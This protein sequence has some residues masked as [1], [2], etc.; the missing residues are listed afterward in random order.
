MICPGWRRGTATSRIQD[1]PRT[2]CRKLRFSVPL[3]GAVRNQGIA[4]VKLV[5]RVAKCLLAERRGREFGN[6][7]PSF[8]GDQVQYPEW[9]TEVRDLV[10]AVR[11]QRKPIRQLSGRKAV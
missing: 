11:V 9:E 6:R 4:G 10:G 8:M 5:A 3:F 7:Q 2:Q 1:H